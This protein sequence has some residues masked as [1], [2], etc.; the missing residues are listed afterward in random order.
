MG[1]SGGLKGESANFIA[2]QKRY[3][4]SFL[5]AYYR[6]NDQIS[7]IPGA[8]TSQADNHNN[9]MLGSG[10]NPK[11]WSIRNTAMYL[12]DSDFDT[13]DEAYADDIEEV[14]SNHIASNSPPPLMSESDLAGKRFLASPDVVRV[15]G[16]G[17]GAI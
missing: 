11:Q 7:M 1:G 14:I 16:S 9:M 13:E 3:I 4:K 10:S 6:F 8:S 12:V 17:E 5:A 15:E 2:L